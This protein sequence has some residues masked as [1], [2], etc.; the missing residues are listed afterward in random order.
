MVNKIFSHILLLGI[1]AGGVIKGATEIPEAAI[2]INELAID[3]LKK[4]EFLI[5]EIN[6]FRFIDPSKNKLKL[7]NS[8]TN[9]ILEI[10]KALEDALQQAKLVEAKRLEIISKVERMTGSTRANFEEKLYDYLAQVD[11]FKKLDYLRLLSIRTD[12]YIEGNRE[13][14]DD[15]FTAGAAKGYFP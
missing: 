9:T 15:F 4:M 14:D 3:D 12:A 2:E 5:K 1:L 13:F 8:S 6:K 7:S 11:I 10:E